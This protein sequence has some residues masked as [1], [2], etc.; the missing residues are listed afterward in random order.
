MGEQ[1]SR[2]EAEVG[3][4]PWRAEAVPWEAGG[5]QV[6]GPRS[7]CTQRRPPKRITRLGLC[8]GLILIALSCREQPGGPQASVGCEPPLLCSGWHT[9]H[10]GLAEDHRAPLVQNGLE[11]APDLRAA[12]DGRAHPRTPPAGQGNRRCLSA[13]KLSASSGAELSTPAP[14]CLRE[15]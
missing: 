13:A 8:A 4:R 10:P 9:A 6:R 7:P 14:R 12:G 2:G 5:Q 3:S 15:A 1:H 11:K